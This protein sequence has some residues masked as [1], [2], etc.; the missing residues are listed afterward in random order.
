LCTNYCICTN[1]C[2]SVPENIFL[3]ESTKIKLNV[4]KLVFSF[5]KVRPKVDETKKEVRYKHLYST[6]Y[7]SSICFFVERK[8]EK[9]GGGGKRREGFSS[10]FPRINLMDIG[11]SSILLTYEYTFITEIL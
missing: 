1:C 8:L 10:G 3:N 2:T 4:Y 6:V 5:K 9:G 11:R 7:E